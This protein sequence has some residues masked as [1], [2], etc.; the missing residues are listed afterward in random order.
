MRPKAICVLLDSIVSQIK[1]PDEIIIIDG[2]LNEETKDILKEKQYNLNIRYFLVEK[3][4]RGLTRQRN[5]GVERVR[6]DMDL[7]AFLDDD[8]RLDVNYFKELVEPYINDDQVIGVG[9]C[10]TNEVSWSKQDASTVCTNRY[11]CIDGYVRKESLRYRL[12]GL[13]GLVPSTQP[14]VISTYSHE[15]PVAFLPPSDKYYEV[16]FMMGGIAS[17]KKILFDQISFS[18]YFE[19]YGLYED[20]DFTLRARALGKLIVNTKAKLEHLHDPSGRPNKFY[21]GQMVI[22][23]GWY[24]WQVATPKPGVEGTLKWYLNA[25][26]LILIRLINIVTGPK[27]IEACTESFGRIYGLITLLWDTPKVDNR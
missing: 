7:I 26:V 8:I 19:G 17:F 1:V 23:N 20:K 27:R 21:Y 10:T 24:V 3:E 22:R 18:H 25:S 9:G 2:S 6:E 15:R 14:G 4:F 16:D 12:R 13:L 5:Y 11:Y